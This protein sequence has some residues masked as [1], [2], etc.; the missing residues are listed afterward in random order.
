MKTRRVAILAADAVGLARLL[1]EDEAAALATRDEHRRLIGAQVRHHGGHVHE[2]PGDEL[3][4]EFA[5]AV[6]AVQCGVEIQ[7]EIEGRN[8]LVARA[9]RLRWQLGIDLGEVR[10]GADGIAGDAVSVATRMAALA[11]PDGLCVS[12]STHDAARDRVE[13]AFERLGDQHFESLPAPVPAYR[14][15][16]ADGAHRGGVPLEAGPVLPLPEHTPRPWQRALAAFGLLLLAAAA[17]ATAWIVLR[18]P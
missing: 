5:S 16:G 3:L 12:G 10:V 14:A 17:A 9:G 6:D 1:A 18:G 4:A 7:R 15:E 11:E 13:V 8:A 2:A